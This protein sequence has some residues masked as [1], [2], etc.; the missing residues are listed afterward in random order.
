MEKDNFNFGQQFENNQSNPNGL[1]Y[2]LDPASNAILKE[3][4]RDFLPA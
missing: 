3:A 4:V 1:S 2:P